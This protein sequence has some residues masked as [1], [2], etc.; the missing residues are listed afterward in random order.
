MS[1]REKEERIAYGRAEVESRLKSLA[2]NVFEPGVKLTFIMRNP[3]EPDGSMIITD[4]ETPDA[5]FTA[6]SR[7]WRLR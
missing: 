7:T 3:C 5:L 2:D 1:D 4:E 6:I